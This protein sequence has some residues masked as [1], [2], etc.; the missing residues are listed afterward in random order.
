MP[1]E[2]FAREYFERFTVGLEAHNEGDIKQ[3]SKALMNC[4]E[5]VETPNL[6][7]TT[8]GLIFTDVNE[9]VRAPAFSCLVF[10]G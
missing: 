2:N 5:D 9:T 4:A 7:L 8:P 3:L 10:G 1:V 6:D